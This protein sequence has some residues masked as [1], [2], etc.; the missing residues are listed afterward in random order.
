M[1]V[2]RIQGGLATVWLLLPPL[3][4]FIYEILQRVAASVAV[5]FVMSI[6]VCGSV[7]DSRYMC[8]HFTNSSV[9]RAV[10]TSIIA[11]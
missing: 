1:V 11:A 5:S 2:V 7:K 4:P 8:Y 9:F 6:A 10:H 3:E